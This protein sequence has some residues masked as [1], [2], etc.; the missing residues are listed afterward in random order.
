LF[1]KANLYYVS[2]LIALCSD[3]KKRSFNGT[4]R[5]DI[6][7]SCSLGS[8]AES[9]LIEQWIRQD[10]ALKHL[11]MQNNE[12]QFLTHSMLSAIAG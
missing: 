1:F 6:S 11:T 12:R 10:S 2:H 3:R 8:D 4:I 7:H 9:Q 5:L